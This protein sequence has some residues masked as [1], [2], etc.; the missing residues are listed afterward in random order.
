M[1]SREFKRGDIVKHFKGNSYIID[2]I[3]TEKDE[4]IVIYTSLYEPYKTW[5]RLYKEF[6]SKVDT[7]KYPN[8]EQYYRFEHLV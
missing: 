2:E 1:S 4:K 3:T 6:I 8:A 7:N 5:T